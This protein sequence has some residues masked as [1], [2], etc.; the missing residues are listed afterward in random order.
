[1]ASTSAN[2][3]V[4]LDTVDKVPS[5]PHGPALLFERFVKNEGPRQFFACSAFRD[6]KQCSFFKWADDVKE[7][8]DKSQAAFTT[9]C[10]HV[11]QTSLRKRFLIFRKLPLSKR[12]LCCNCGLL[13]LPGET[14]QHKQQ[15]HQIKKGVRRKDLQ[16]PTTLFT[17]QEDNKTYAQYLFS[18]VTVEFILGC[19]ENGHFTHILC[20]G[21]PRIHEAITLRKKTKDTKLTSL[22]LDLDSRYAQVYP[23][24]CLC[25]YNMFNHHFFHRLGEARLRSFLCEREARAVLVTDPPFGGMVEPLAASFHKIEEIW[26]AETALDESLPI[27]LFFPYFMEKRV[28]DVMPS[29]TMLDYKVD[30]DNHTLF[31]NKKGKRKKGSPVRI[32]TN[33]LPAALPLPLSE[34]YWFCK[35][36]QRYSAPENQHC[37]KC[38]SCTSKD[39]TKY[40][41]CDICQ[42]CVKSTRIHCKQ[43]NTCELLTHTCGLKRGGGCH[44]CGAFGHKRRDCPER[45]NS[46][47]KQ[48]NSHLKRSAQEQMS[49]CAKKRRR[50]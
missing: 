44:I 37:P 19:L 41:H 42:R 48:R 16:H 18:D 4:I 32:F 1:M 12:S 43:C 10:A 33:L 26:K 23:A 39:G 3:D 50:Q 6:R 27:L 29:L 21:A 2:I 24:K 11:N 45:H 20:V 35:D 25:L 30:Y 31:Q 7:K 5:C 8:S 49:N 38:N 46:N 13:L 36:C 22:L 47:Q 40:I 9:S 34:G 28:C 15:G 17:P 14:N